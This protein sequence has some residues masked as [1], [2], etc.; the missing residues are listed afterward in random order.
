MATE[1][2]LQAVRRH[3]QFSDTRMPSLYSDFR[4]LKES[5]W[6]GYESNLRAWKGALTSAL[7][8]GLFSDKLMIEAGMSLVEKLSDPR[9][10]RPLA[11]DEV[12]DELVADKTLMPLSVFRSHTQSILA[13]RWFD[14]K[15]IASWALTKTG[16]W[17]T[18]WKSALK[19]GA[20][21]EEKY[22]DLGTL[23]SV[24]NSAL[25]ALKDQAVS[26]TS[27]LYSRDGAAVVIKKSHTDLSAQDIEVVLMYLS[28]DRE[29]IAMDG[30]YIKVF[31]AGVSGAITEKDRAVVNLK[32]VIAQVSDRV[33]RLS[34]RIDSDSVR[35][36]EAIKRS[37][38]ALAK[39]ALRS[40]KSVETSQTK[41]LEMLE[42][43]ETVLTKIDEAAGQVEV[44][45]ALQSG[46]SILAD[47]NREVGGAERVSELMDNVREQVDETDEVG[48]E[49]AALTANQVDEA[50]VDDEL[51]ALLRDETAEKESQKEPQKQSQKE[52]TEDALG[53]LASPP[54]KVPE[55]NK[56]S[57]ADE[58]IDRLSGELAAMEV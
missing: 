43:L 42:N 20:L 7:H 38:K 41:S 19:G 5:N 9:F 24:A 40:K 44:V 6:D 53:R 13:R 17:D 54:T 55:T 31:G 50:D 10:G 37:N 4:R 33:H 14:A 57:E 48:R 8:E 30:D 23:E 34:L 45:S 2:L 21:K 15:G 56:R 39:Y 32:N 12:L 26:Y 49:I 51:E 16:L 25:A 28:R 36:R 58:A 52:S 35:A 11:V 29:S 22:I 18:T 46:A 27:S 1:T 47:L 3:Q